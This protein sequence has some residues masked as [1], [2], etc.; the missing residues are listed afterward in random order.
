MIDPT[1]GCI[2]IFQYPLDGDRTR[3]PG[4]GFFYIQA[5]SL[6]GAEEKIEM[7]RHAA[8]TEMPEDRKRSV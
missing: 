7:Q 5:E 4:R 2:I 6:E 8:Q 3:D 1:D